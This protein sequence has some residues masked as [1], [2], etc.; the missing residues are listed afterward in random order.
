MHR[1]LL[2]LPLLIP[3]TT[4][5]C[6]DL[7]PYCE[8]FKTLDLCTSSASQQ[9]I[10]KYNCAQTCEFCGKKAGSCVDRLSNCG[11][12]KLTGLCE[13]DDKLR[14]EYACPVTCNVCETPV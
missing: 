7:H 8:L 2:I 4:S 3:F 6:R 5:Q 12:Y 1:L 13:T 11:E 10:M 14:I 9:P